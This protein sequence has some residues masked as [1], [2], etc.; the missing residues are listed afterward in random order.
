MKEYDPCNDPDPR[1]W[2]DMDEGQRI[3]MVRRYH[4]KAG[5]DLPN[6]QIH[7]AVHVIVENQI[8]EGDSIP[9]R[10]TLVRLMSEGLNRHDAVHAIAG[11]LTDL[12]YASSQDGP[13]EDTN[14]AY[15]ANLRSLTAKGWLQKWENC[16]DAP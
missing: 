7:A 15:L 4:R 10:Q 8:A 11:V 1:A 6:E 13:P 3:E 9:V 14:A 5:I 12:I 2:K 16:E